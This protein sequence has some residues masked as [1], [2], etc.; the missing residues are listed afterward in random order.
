MG[1]IVA[2]VTI[3]NTSDPSK[4]LRCDALVDTGAACMT[5]PIA[6]K[7]RPGPLEQIRTVDVET[8]TQQV[9]DASICGPVRIEI[10]GFPPVF[11]EVRFLDMAPRDGWYKP[12]IGYIPLEQSQA[13]VDRL[14]HRLVYVKHVDLK[15]VDQA[16][17]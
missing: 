10:E 13:A 1:R 11:G 12:L 16:D 6:W 4:S 3:T 14:E 5:P 8:A 7:E 2:S 15:K 17:E 9:V